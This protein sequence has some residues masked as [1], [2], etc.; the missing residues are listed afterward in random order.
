MANKLRHNIHKWNDSAEC[1]TS[2]NLKQNVKMKASI[3]Y[4]NLYNA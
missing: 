2:K 3:S 4:K 1:H